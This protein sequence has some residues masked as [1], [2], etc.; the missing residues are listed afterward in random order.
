MGEKGQAGGGVPGWISWTNNLATT[1]AYGAARA[2]GSVGLLSSRALRWYSNAWKGNQYVETYNLT[3]FGWRIGVGTAIVGAFIGTVD[4]TLSD[5]S[6]GDYGQLGVS[7]LSAGLT[8]DG[9]TAPAGIGIG[10]FDAGGGF[11]SFYNYLDLNQQLYNGTGGLILP[12]N[13]VPQYFQIK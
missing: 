2:G 7:L 10:L 13:G 12:I 8:L 5:K 3:K 4:F 11:N 1:V 6:W 9:F